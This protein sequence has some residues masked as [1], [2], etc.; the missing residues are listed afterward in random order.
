[1]LRYSFLAN[2]AESQFLIWGNPS[3][4]KNFANLMRDSHTSPATKSLVDLGCQAQTGETVLLV[5]INNQG[6]GMIP[7][8]GSDNLF[9]WEN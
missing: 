1:M 7:S 4:V 5:P 8:D 6:R 3:D 2:L 9:L